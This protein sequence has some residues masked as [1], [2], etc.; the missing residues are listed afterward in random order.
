MS[1]EITDKDALE[2]IER[3]ASTKSISQRIREIVNSAIC[4]VEE[5]DLKCNYLVMNAD[6]YVIIRKYLKDDMEEMGQKSILLT[7]RFA[8]LYN[9]ITI[10][11]SK[12]QKDI[13]GFCWED[14][15]PE[16]VN[17]RLS[18]SL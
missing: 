12:E 6:D 5:Q 13:E 16:Y 10:I 4:R 1:T 18:Y 15:L 7:G 17:K 3:K 11:V 9:D 2:W 14:T 8:L